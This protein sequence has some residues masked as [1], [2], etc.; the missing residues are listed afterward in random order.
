MKPSKQDILMLI[1]YLLLKF[2]ANESS[3]VNERDRL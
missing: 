3:T 2:E 1:I